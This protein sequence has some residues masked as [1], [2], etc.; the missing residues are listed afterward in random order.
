MYAWCLAIQIIVPIVPQAIMLLSRLKSSK[1]STAAFHLDFFSPSDKMP[2]LCI[3]GATL[4]WQKC[5]FLTWRY[6]GDISIPELHWKMPHIPS[7]YQ[8]CTE[9][10][11]NLYTARASL[12]IHP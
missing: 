2:G 5:D 4:G 3:T 9:T 1:I 11:P 6:T 8:I 7:S 12:F 10:F